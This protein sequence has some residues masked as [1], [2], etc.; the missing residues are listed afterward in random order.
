MKKSLAVILSTILVFT[1]LVPSFLTFAS[2]EDSVYVEAESLNPITI[3]EQTSVPEE[4]D[5]NGIL[6]LEGGYFDIERDYSQSATIRVTNT[7]DLSVEYYLTVLN[8]NDDIYLNFVR[9]G[10]PEI[11]LVIAA[12][13][14]QEIS[15]DIFAQN[16]KKG[17]YEFPIYAHTIIND[18]EVVDARTTA[19]VSC[20][21]VDLNV[22]ITKIS[23]DPNTLAQIYSL[24]NNGKAISDLEVSV[25][26]ELYDYVLL[27]PAN[28]N[29]YVKSGEVIE[30][31]ALPDLTKMKMD[32]VDC[33]EGQ[34]VASA[35]GDSASYD[36]KFDTEGQE[37]STI[38]VG[39]LVALQMNG[40][41]TE[42][43]QTK[44][45]DMGT[46]T[47]QNNDY[48]CTNAG[49]STIKQRF[50]SKGTG[51]ISSKSA[52]DNDVRVFMT[53]RMYGG[54]DVYKYYG[55]SMS[56]DYVDVGETHYDYYINGV[57]AVTSQNT[58]VTEVAI[59][60]LPTDNIKFGAMN[61]IVRDYDT[62]PGHYFVTANTEISILYPADTIIGYIGSPETL[63]DY[64]SLPDFAVYAENIFNSEK[65]FV[66]G[67]ESEIKINVYNRGSMGG[68]FD[69]TVSDNDGVVYSEEDRYLEAFSGDKI[70]FAWTPNDEAEEI[71]V[72][73]ENTTEGLVEDELS[74]NTA[75]RKFAVRE[76]VKP[77]IQSI[78]PDY[79]VEGEAI[80]YATVSNYEDVTDVRFYV[81]DQLYT[82]EVKSS[83]YSGSMRYWINDSEMSVGSHKIKVVVE[84][85][86][87]NTTTATV[88]KIADFNV[89]D[90]KWN[91]FTLKLD[92]NIEYPNFYLYD[93]TRGSVKYINNISRE[94]QKYTYYMTKA[95][96]DNKSGFEI[97]A[98]SENAVLFTT[99][100]NNKD[101]ML[102]D[103]NSLTF[104]GDNV[105]V[106]E[107]YIKEVNNAEIY[108]WVDSANTLKLMP[109][110][111]TIYVGMSY[112]GYYKS[113]ELDVNMTS[114]DVNVDL[115]KYFDI[116]TFEFKD[117]INGYPNA[118][119]YYQ[120]E[121]NNY[122]DAVT[123]NTELIDN[124]ALCYLDFDCV[125][126]HNADKAFVVFTTNDVMFVDDLDL[127]N[128][129][130][131]GQYSIDKSKLQHYSLSADGSV[132]DFD[133]TDVEVACD[134]FTAWLFSSEI[135]VTPGEYSIT[136]YCRDLGEVDAFSSQSSLI[137]YAESEDLEQVDIAFDISSAYNR[138][139]TVFGSGKTN[140][141]I[142]ED[143]Y[144][145]GSKIKANKDEYNFNINVFRN[146]AVYNILSKVDA[147]DNVV[148]PI[149][150]YFNGD[151]INSFG[152][153]K[154]YSTVRLYVDNLFDEN[155][156]ELNSFNA[157]SEEDKL[158]GQLIFTNVENAEDVAYVWVELDN[159]SYVDVVL[160]E[161]DGTYN[162]KLSVSTDSELNDLKGIKL[163]ETEVTIICRD[164]HQLEVNSI[165]EGIDLSNLVWTSSD[166][167]VVNVDENGLVTTNPLQKGTSVITVTTADGLYSATCE[168]TV[169]FTAVQWIFWFLTFG[170]LRDLFYR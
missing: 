141:S 26:G 6:E 145:S 118:T 102:D 34:I 121:S 167:R 129:C 157:K 18:S 140:S 137:T 113:V 106:E 24:K 84:Y 22:T 16:T 68:T 149:G 57:K 80:V 108:N 15:L 14:T 115:S 55:G 81:D 35:G 134:S 76:R 169:N 61:T 147:N 142:S 164:S 161:L 2:E 139:A 41:S 32:N 31:T 122:W 9:S 93:S 12:G 21:V 77:S 63:P 54:D 88:E 101:L 30:F 52:N 94:G 155:G 112:M 49:K 78:T 156:N 59:V 13:E 79:A 45:Y 82:G 58:G 114:G 144:L 10:S 111:Y 17:S 107:M 166:E 136:V 43:L 152:A 132:T 105:V 89:F 44:A 116:L 120:S 143:E 119:V 56:G 72:T 73:I 91:Q 48:Q 11:P 28:E 159:L 170:C 25:A 123:L 65:N 47:I 19:Y 133:I 51:G 39:E 29:V 131:Q 33:I 74:N 95:E 37:I 130:V 70:S 127:S 165:P 90:S 87:S 92:E 38:T 53:S 3:Q 64:R 5:Y 128:G 158:F 85:A 62:N 160:P 163:S 46:I 110:E 146:E 69:I 7:S 148:K 104:S 138:Y 126:L 36:T 109:A 50:P 153:Y 100:D 97:I 23:E 124:K 67:N 125:E 27:T 98:A 42:G 150:N 40:F 4:D 96:Y 154:A 83:P 71:T 99:L 75:S 66:V 60:E 1:M 86:D 20:P 162:I 8:V 103:C 151:I 117:E 135:Y 168:V